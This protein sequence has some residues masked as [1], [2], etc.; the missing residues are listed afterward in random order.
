MNV[1]RSKGMFWLA[2][3]PGDAI[4]WSQAG[5]SS[6]AETYGKWWASMPMAQRV[7]R[8][9]FM[10]NQEALMKKWDKE[11]GDRMNELVIIGTELNPDLVRKQLETCL[12]NT[13]E[14]LQWKAKTKFEDPW[15]I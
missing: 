2:S 7:A 12:L 4:L 14:M 6:K 11:F 1:I 3:R 10:E 5:G 15:P 13:V 9:D 8:P